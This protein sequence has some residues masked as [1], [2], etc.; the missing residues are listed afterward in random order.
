MGKPGQTNSTSSYGRTVLQE[1]RNQTQKPGIRKKKKK[2][3][4]RCNPHCYEKLGKL[5]HSKQQKQPSY[6]QIGKG[7]ATVRTY[8]LTW[9][10]SENSPTYRI[11]SAETCPAPTLF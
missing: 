4:K 5:S 2:K 10:D 9:Q 3:V 6:G 8:S 11:T 1:H 7:L